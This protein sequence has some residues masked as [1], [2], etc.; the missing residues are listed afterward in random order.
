M[1]F[2]LKYQ[3]GYGYNYGDDLYIY[4]SDIWF[5]FCTTRGKVGRL[6]N[7]LLHNLL[8]SFKNDAVYFSS[9][10]FPS[11]NSSQIHFTSQDSYFTQLSYF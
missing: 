11:P 9:Y 1:I 4:L 2:I 8:L 10:F 3:K 6:F 5:S 7:L